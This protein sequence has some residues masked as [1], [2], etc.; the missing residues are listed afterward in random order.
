MKSNFTSSRTKSRTATTD[1]KC[2]L[3]SSETLHA[4]L[5]TVKIVYEEYY[6][7][8]EIDRMLG[9]MCVLL[10]STYFDFPNVGENNVLYVDESDSATYVWNEE[11]ATYTCIGRDFTNINIIDGG[12]ALWQM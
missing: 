10:K 5:S 2:G 11:N 6:N 8:R 12:D 4:E 9:E 7:K 3:S 1:H